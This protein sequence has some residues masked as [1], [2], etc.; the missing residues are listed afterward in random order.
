MAVPDDGV[1]AVGSDVHEAVV[2]LEGELDVRV[3]EEERMER[4]P[5][6][7]RTEAHRRGDAQRAREPAAALRDLA[8]RIG[9]FLQD[10][11]RPHE[12]GLAFR[13]EAE[14]ARGALDEMRA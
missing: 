14:L 7:Q 2:E 11:P 12:K 6:M 8:P 1:E 5:E 9:G 3:R 10:A 4:A 13:G